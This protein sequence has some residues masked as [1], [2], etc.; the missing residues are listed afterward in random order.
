MQRGALVLAV[1]AGAW[2]I[3]LVAPRY[4]ASDSSVSIVITAEEFDRIL[5][6]MSYDDCVRIIGATGTPFGASNEPG[7]EAD[8]PE[9]V[10]YSWRNHADSYAYISFEKGRVDRKQAVNLP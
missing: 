5:P 4:T 2:G 8:S 7:A 10:S 9:W 1:I 6:G 3:L